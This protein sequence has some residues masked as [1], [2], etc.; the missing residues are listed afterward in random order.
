MLA[1]AWRVRVSAGADAGFRGVVGPA[2]VVSVRC[3]GPSKAT[4]PVSPFLSSTPASA[5]TVLHNPPVQ[6][7]SGAGVTRSAVGACAAGEARAGEAGA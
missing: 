7:A 1:L 5:V 3:G 6:Y 4:V 2:G